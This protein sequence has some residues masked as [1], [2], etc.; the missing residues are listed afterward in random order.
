M[1]QQFPEAALIPRR[2]NSHFEVRLEVS[3]AMRRRSFSG[4]LR[5]DQHG[6]FAS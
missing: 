6:R 2:G 1:R 3:T 5:L 4:P